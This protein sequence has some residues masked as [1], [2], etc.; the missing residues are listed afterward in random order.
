MRDI[1]NLA[2]WARL[3]L[4]LAALTTWGCSDS[5]PALTPPGVTNPLV[6][7]RA[8]PWAYRTEGGTYYF[9]ATVP[10]FNRIEL[11]RADQLGQLNQ[12]APSVIWRKHREGPMSAN[13]WAPELHRIDGTWY[14]YFSAGSREKPRDIRLYAL[15]NETEDPM[16]GQWRELGPIETRHNTF[17]LDSTPFIHRGQR[18]LI[19]SQKDPQDLQP[20]SLHIARMASPTEVTG[21]EVLIAKPEHDWEKRG[22][23]A[24][25]GASVVKHEG[26]IFV[27]YTASATDHRSAIGLLWADAKAD[28]MDPA[29]WHKEPIPVFATN[30]DL[31]R[32]GPGHPSITLADDG[33]TWVMLYHSREYVDL[34]GDQLEDPNRHTRA[35]IVRWNEDN[36]PVLN[37]TQA[38]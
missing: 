16:T 28:L 20:A 22:I 26:R 18:Y 30:T 15:A 10:E 35:R 24:N 29:S 25:Q 19:W 14:I 4:V 12:A 32:Q 8:D 27:F 21:P 31:N 11:R 34:H 9:T 33:R 3:G 23:P 13:I 7:Q 5:E 17:A 6:Q 37:P 38:D 36:K 1:F 2:V